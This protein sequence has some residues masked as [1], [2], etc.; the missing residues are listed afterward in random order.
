MRVV[1]F[2]SVVVVIEVKVAMI[3]TRRMYM[4]V[5]MGDRRVNVLMLVH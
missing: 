2:C 5:R 1:V 4:L 3:A